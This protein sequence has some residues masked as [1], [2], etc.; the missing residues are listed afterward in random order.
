MQSKPRRGS[1]VP[2]QSL[3]AMRAVHTHTRTVCRCKGPTPVPTI[4]QP[5]H[6]TVYTGVT[7]PAAHAAEACVPAA[8]QAWLRQANTEVSRNQGRTHVSTSW[9]R[10]TPHSHVNIP[11]DSAAGVTQPS[12]PLPPACMLARNWQAEDGQGTKRETDSCL[13]AKNTACIHE[14]RLRTGAWL[15][16]GGTS[17][18]GSRHERQH[19]PRLCMTPAQAAVILGTNTNCTQEP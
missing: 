9:Y 15:Q 19:P 16:M 1:K 4:K 13:R 11:T 2:A 7:C 12:H 8:T 18:A 10:Q 5:H 3:D 6:T 17:E 14:P